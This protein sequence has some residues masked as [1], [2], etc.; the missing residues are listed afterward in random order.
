MYYILPHHEP[1]VHLDI[2]LHLDTVTWSANSNQIVISHN[3]HPKVTWG[4]IEVDNYHDPLI[5]RRNSPSNIHRD[6]SKVNH[7][8]RSTPACNISISL[9]TSR[10]VVEWT[11]CHHNTAYADVRAESLSDSSRLPE[12]P[13][14]PTSK[15]YQSPRHLPASRIRIFKWA[16]THSGSG[17]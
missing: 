15:N 3:P 10:L 2:S 8:R 9:H 6:L 1:L 12:N 17:P 7:R 11:Y 16:P 5:S 4:S 13:K 14:D